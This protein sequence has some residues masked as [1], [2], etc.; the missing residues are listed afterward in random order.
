MP[1]IEKRQIV[2]EPQNRYAV[3][4]FDLSRENIVGRSGMMYLDTPDVPELIE[5]L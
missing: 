4:Y 5:N 1:G 3:A 2:L